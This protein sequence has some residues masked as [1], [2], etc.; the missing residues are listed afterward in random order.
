MLCVVA[1]FLFFAPAPRCP[2]CSISKYL[3]DFFSFIIQ[4]AAGVVQYYVLYMCK[5]IASLS[6]LSIYLYQTVYLSVYLYSVKRGVVVV[7]VTVFAII[8]I[9]IECALEWSELT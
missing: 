6:I 3:F 7:I 2:S 1:C 8:A 4:L 5:P 9:I